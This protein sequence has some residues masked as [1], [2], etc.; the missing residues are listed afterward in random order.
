MTNPRKREDFITPGL[1]TI[2]INI[3]V[4]DKPT[5]YLLH[6]A[7]ELLPNMIFA[8]LLYYFNL[9]ILKK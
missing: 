5:D 9:F 8:F 1:P 7:A 2:K 4:V 6:F 3:Y